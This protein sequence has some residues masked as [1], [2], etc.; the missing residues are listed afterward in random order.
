[1]DQ[2]SAAAPTAKHGVAVDFGAIELTGSLHHDDAQRDL[3][4]L[5]DEGPERVS[6]SL[7]GYG[8]VPAPGRVFVK[9]W[10]EHSGLAQRLQEAGLA[11]IVGSVVV[12]PFSSTA[13]E[14]EVTL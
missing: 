1:M 5:T 7:Q 10:S 13:Y 11:R 9:D 3:V 4:L 6:V 12:G 14:V 2:I 8:L